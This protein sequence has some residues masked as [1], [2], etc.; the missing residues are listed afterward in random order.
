MSKSTFSQAVRAEYKNE[1]RE[2]KIKG[3][4]KIPKQSTPLTNL[5]PTYSG[6]YTYLNLT[7]EINN[8][9]VK[10]YGTT[11]SSSIDFPNYPSLTLQAGR[12]KLKMNITKNTNNSYIGTQFGEFDI[13]YNPNDDYPNIYAYEKVY[14]QSHTINGIGFRFPNN[15]NID[16]EFDL[17]LNEI[18]DDI[19]TSLMPTYNAQESIGNATLT[20]NNDIFTMQGNNGYNTG[21]GIQY[22][23]FTLPAG[24]YGLRIRTIS[25]T[26]DFGIIINDNNYNASITAYTDKNEY[27]ELKEATTFN[28]AQIQTPNVN[29]NY[30]DVYELLLFEDVENQKEYDTFTIGEGTTLGE[31]PN[32]QILNFNVDETSDIYYEKMPF[33]E[34]CVEVDNTDGY[35]SDFT[36]NSITSL[37]NKDCY[38]DIYLDVNNTD[39]CKSWT[40]QFDRLSADN[41]SAKLYFKPYVSSVIGLEQ[42]Y[43]KNKQFLDNTGIWDLEKFNSYMKTN[44][45][46]EIEEDETYTGRIMVNWA[47]SKNIDSMLLQFAS[48]VGNNEKGQILSI[49]ENK[50]LR[51]KRFVV[52]GTTQDDITSDIIIQ[53]PIITKETL[54]GIV[55]KFISIKS[56]TSSPVNWQKQV[57]GVLKEDTDVLVVY[58]ND[59]DLSNVSTSDITITG[60]SLVSV[61]H[62]IS[63]GAMGLGS[64]YLLLEI[65]G[66]AGERYTININASV[67]HTDEIS[68]HEEIYAKG[69]YETTKDFIKL[70]LDEVINTYYWEQLLNHLQKKI[71]FQVKALPYLQVGDS[72]TLENEGNVV[73]TE[74]HTKWN[75]GFLMDV[76]AYKVEYFLGNN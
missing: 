43:D 51:Y 59:Y 60:A 9:H 23:S 30:D 4:I 38:I 33:S 25:G 21:S 10:I 67:P 41:E 1:V 15:E 52:N 6:T 65:S 46:V 50:K 20:I 69:S 3:D 22:Q 45:D 63:G 73:I 76:V 11:S 56:Y 74:L 72:I 12:Y 75:N 19:N 13:S 24:K 29:T 36:E 39:W 58:E 70:Q 53:K 54:Q 62:S 14:T 40:M 42:L 61:S 28:Y 37:L 57:D 27:I 31:T 44:Y 34:M 18:E 2:I 8:Q 68:S 17:I 16:V 32:P 71:T 49:K 55:N 35:F 5:M 47:G 7:M 26:N 66:N 64:H 48:A